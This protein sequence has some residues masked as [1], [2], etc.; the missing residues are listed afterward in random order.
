MGLGDHLDTK[1]QKPPVTGIITAVG[2]DVADFG[3]GDRVV[4]GQF[5]GHRFEV[6]DKNYL[7]LKETDLLAVLR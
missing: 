5:A 1:C 4:F 2:P 6:D 7:L 3:V